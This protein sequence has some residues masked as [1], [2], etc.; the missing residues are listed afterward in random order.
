MVLIDKFWEWEDH[1]NGNSGNGDKENKGNNTG[2]K[3]TEKSEKKNKLSETYKVQKTKQNK[4]N[5]HFNTDVFYK[6]TN[7]TYNVKESCQRRNLKFV[8][9]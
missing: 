4:T 5:T 9:Q 1:S 3:T 6:H 7:I 2:N 8:A